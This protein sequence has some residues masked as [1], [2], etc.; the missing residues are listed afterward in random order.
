MSPGLVW[1]S[2][3]NGAGKTTL[4]EAVYLLDRGR[5]FRG[6]RSGPV[7]TRGEVGTAVAGGIRDG[8]RIR[9]LRWSSKTVRRDGRGPAWSRF[10]GA[11]SFNIV[12]GDPALRRRFL[13]W[14]LFHVEPEARDQWA[15]LQRLQ[16]QRNA[17]LSAGGGGKS[18][19]DPPY[20]EALAG[21]WGR[22]T[23]FADRVDSAFRA[24]TADLAPMGELSIGWRWTGQGR[25]LAALLE[26][27]RSGDIERGHTFLSPSRGDLV[28]HANGT[29]WSGSRGENKLAGMVL[30]LAIQCVVTDA[31]G[32]RQAVLM[33]DP[34]AEVST[35]SVV[36]VI[37]AWVRAAEQVIVTSLEPPSSDVTAG[38]GPLL[39]HVEQGECSP[40]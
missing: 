23:A 33:D 14:S 20:V 30:Q 38:L 3:A 6:R 1:L 21:V 28:F 32:V 11:S 24:L 12:D 13:D 36:P 9:Q 25:D 27:H 17:W 40:A 34:Y 18:V 31:T 15:R 29:P 22:R 5:T 7:T 10:V 16:R 4:L 35:G 37:E 39:F 2:G 19:W 8:D 26:S